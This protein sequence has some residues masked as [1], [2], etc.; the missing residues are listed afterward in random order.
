MAYHQYGSQLGWPKSN[1]GE[2]WLISQRHLKVNNHPAQSYVAKRNGGGRL[3]AIGS[4]KATASLHQYQ[5]LPS[6]S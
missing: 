3:V 1:E 6:G 4:V 5:W 2:M